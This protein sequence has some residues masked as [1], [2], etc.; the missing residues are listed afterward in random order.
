M[1]LGNLSP[2][3]I[4]K[5]LK[6]N[7]FGTDPKF[8]KISDLDWLNVKEGEYDN[9]PTANNPVRVLPELADQWTPGA[10]HSGLTLL[11]LKEIPVK[12]SAK[13]AEKR[14]A[15]QKDIIRSAKRAIMMGL[16]GN[17]ISNQLRMRYSSSD[18][19][20]VKDKLAEV[21]KE[22]GLL[23]NVYVDISAFTSPNDAVTFLR[24]NYCKT[25]RFLLV[26]KGFSQAGVIQKTFRKAAV[27]A[28]EYTPELLNDYKNFLVLSGRIPADYQIGSKE[29]LRRAFLYCTPNKEIVE[30]V[31]KPEEKPFDKEAASE[32][33]TYR[34]ALKKVS[35]DTTK[36]LLHLR[37][38]YPIV[39][40]AQEIIS[41]G[42][43]FED[44]KGTLRSK[45][46]A[47][48]IKSAAPYLSMV[49][50]GLS[51]ESIDK[52]KSEDK[53]SF[54]V[55]RELKKLAMACPTPKHIPDG[56]KTAKQVGTPGY[57]CNPDYLNGLYQPPRQ[58]EVVVGDLFVNTNSIDGVI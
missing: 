9:Y 58:E 27:S 34:S 42:K 10:K 55:A 25:A 20:A 44:V 49:A 40:C 15:A 6:P 43:S 32:D 14:E 16:S 11:N 57:L 13:E 21:S 47:E 35:D 36:D 31:A 12:D 56:N 54:E 45:F 26:P 18:L 17:Q 51:E 2:E 46:L 4:G 28:I 37:S 8:P 48:D 38:I 19:E 52:L 39:K 22:Q 30:T 7:L 23:G 5:N 53:L 50:K 41:K 24:G 1:D 33:L 29:D 3:I